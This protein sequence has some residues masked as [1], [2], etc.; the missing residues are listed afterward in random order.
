MIIK[1]GLSYSELVT[2]RKLLGLANQS[3][4]TAIS[5]EIIR[6]TLDFPQETKVRQNSPKKM[7][8]DNKTE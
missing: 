2:L 1:Q 8:F 7:I 4:K 5:K 3:Q 6:D